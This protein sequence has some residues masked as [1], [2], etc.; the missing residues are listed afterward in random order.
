MAP[1]M[2]TGL[3]FALS[4]KCSLLNVGAK[5]QIYMGGMAAMVVA[6][7]VTGLPPALHM[8]LCV[9]AGVLAGAIWGGVAGWLKV[10]FNADEM[11][12]TIML[13]YIATSFANYMVTNVMRAPEGTLP[14]S[15][16]VPESARLIQFSCD[17][18]KYNL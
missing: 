6:Q 18:Y 7:F 5:G 11:I 12:T 1:L 3:A 16:R 2:L 15:A 10:R 17:Q 8:P 9:L 13:N 4:A 14:Q